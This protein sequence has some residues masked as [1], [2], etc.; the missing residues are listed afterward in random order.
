LKDTLK[1]IIP[2]NKAIVILYLVVFALIIPAQ[3]ADLSQFEATCLDIGFKKK[4]EAFG[5]CVIELVSREKQ[6]QSSVQANK[7]NNIKQRN[8]SDTDNYKKER[9]QKFKADVSTTNKFQPEISNSTKRQNKTNNDNTNN[10][11]KTDYKDKK[12]SPEHKYQ[13]SLLKA[14]HPDW[15]ELAYSDDFAKWQKT[16][17]PNEQNLMNNS[18]DGKKIAEYITQFKNWKENEKLSLQSAR[19]NTKPLTLDQIRQKYPIYSGFSD[20]VLAEYLHEK[21]YGDMPFKDYAK[22][23]G[24]ENL[25]TAPG[26]ARNLGLAVDKNVVGVGDVLERTGK[27]DI[28]MRFL[29]L[30]AY[31]L[32]STILMYVFGALLIYKIRL[33]IATKIVGFFVAWLVTVIT[34]ILMADKKTVLSAELEMFP[35]AAFGV[36]VALFVISVAGRRIPSAR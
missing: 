4:T 7:K 3:A 16:L 10:K 31:A 6:T 20:S 23:I 8:E 26:R 15:E 28:N 35:A 13:I 33:T 5:N 25:E 29:Q 32:P 2:T 19:F 24:Y 12:E 1:M 30:L 11:L 34:A 27:M 9:I 21:Y 18:W 22:A 17:S 36:I 14:I